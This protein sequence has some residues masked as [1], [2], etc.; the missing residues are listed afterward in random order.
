MSDSDFRKKRRSSRTPLGASKPVWKKLPVVD[1]FTYTGSYLNFRFA[2]ILLAGALSFGVAGF[3][4]LEGYSFREA[5][6]MTIITISTVGYTEVRPL[7]PNGQIFVSI[8]IIFYIGVFS[9]VVSAFTFYVIQGEFFKQIHLNFL[10]KRIKELKNHIIICGYGKYGKEIAA[11]FLAHH[12]PFVVIERDQ[13][14]VEAIQKGEARIVYIQDDATHDEALIK[15][16]IEH[17]RSLISALP[18]DT[19]NVFTV[20]TARQLN[21]RI[22]IISRARDP[23]SQRKLLRAGANHVVMPEQIGGFYMA[24]LVAKPGAVEFFSFI[25]NHYGSDIDFEEIH[26]EQLPGSCQGRTIRDLA[27]RKATGANI[28]GFKKA[29][30]EF[31]VNPGPDV[32]MEPGSSFIL[33]G[34][35]EHLQSMHDYLNHYEEQ[36][37]LSSGG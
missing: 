10:A 7:S 34:N 15:A 13:E 27:I 5:F 26:Y 2:L 36:R 35:S 21:P 23:R 28:I 6:Y 16:G 3:V 17:A 14:E 20:L 9:Y 31:I 25:T 29:N 33:M 24:T 11:H 37:P 19:E 12:M 18:D 32:I 30:G 8:L 4:F 22:N 1:F